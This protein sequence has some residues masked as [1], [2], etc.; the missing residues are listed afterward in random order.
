VSILVV[1][2][3][4]TTLTQDINLTNNHRYQVAAFRPKIFMYNAPAGTFTLSLKSGANVLQSVTFTSAEI[5]SDLNTTDNYAWLWKALI[6]DNPLPVVKGTYTLELSSSGYSF[7]NSSY[8]GWIKDFNNLYNERSEVFESYQTN[9]LTFQIYT[10]KR[11]ELAN[12]SRLID[13]ADGF[14]T[15]NA[16]VTLGGIV[17]V[18]NQNITNGGQIALDPAADQ[19]LKV[20]GSGGAVT[21][22][23]TP[24]S[25]SVADGSIVRLEGQ[26][27]TNTVTLV[28][29]DAAGGC[30]LNGN[31]TLGKQ[32]TLHLRYD[33]S[34]DR[35]IELGR[36][37]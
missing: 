1:E 25:G 33:A 32:D 27:N 30:I 24:F 3:L 37:F 21:A 6:F 13:F 5:K 11:G 29:N 15:P 17:V 34:D 2:E 16:P 36:N 10:K 26:D 4:F 18:A 14:S 22:S 9:P 19:V 23:I 8:L 31:A 20:T 7:T 35:Y 28:H 12:M